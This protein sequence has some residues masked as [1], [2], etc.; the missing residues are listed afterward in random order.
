M[1]E[2]VLAIVFLSLCV[3][4]LPILPKLTG[5]RDYNRQLRGDRPLRQIAGNTGNFFSPFDIDGENGIDP[6]MEQAHLT[7]TLCGMGCKMYSEGR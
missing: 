7:S 5:T 6:Q 1:F 2:S 4:V 3:I